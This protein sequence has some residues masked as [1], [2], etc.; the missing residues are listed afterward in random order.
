L[1][2]GGRLVEGSLVGLVLRAE[3]NDG[4]VLKACTFAE[5]GRCWFIG[6]VSFRGLSQ[7]CLQLSLQE[8]EASAMSAARRSTS[9]W[10]RAMAVLDAA[11][12]TCGLRR[13]ERLGE[14]A[15][16]LSRVN[17]LGIT[18]SFETALKTRPRCAARLAAKCGSFFSIVRSGWSVGCRYLWPHIRKSC[19]SL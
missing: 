18:A 4:A 8:A 6:P 7:V 15:P 14:V 2:R 11:N 1:K 19:N 10:I 16:L 9:S 13:R 5:P 3:G 12:R 17:C